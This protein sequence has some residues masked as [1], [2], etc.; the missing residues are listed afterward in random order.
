[1]SGGW[2]S[3]VGNRWDW[4][5][6]RGGWLE[7]PWTSRA[8]SLEPCACCRRTEAAF[9]PDLGG[10]TGGGHSSL[11][12]LHFDSAQ[13]GQG[14]SSWTWPATWSDKPAGPGGNLVREETSSGKSGLGLRQVQVRNLDLVW[15]APT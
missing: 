13:P 5:L 14:S 9:A 6:E 12:D 7:R 3:A 2:R 4:I 15:E 8:D 11:R 1:M 10:S